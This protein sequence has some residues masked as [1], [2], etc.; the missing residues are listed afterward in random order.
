MQ[1]P[2][3]R[4]GEDANLKKKISAYLSSTEVGKLNQGP[5]SLYTNA[6]IFE[7]YRMTDLTLVIGQHMSKLQYNTA[8]SVMEGHRNTVAAYRICGILVRMGIS[9][10]QTLMRS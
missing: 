2:T 8:Q 9:Q 5:E 1:S 10:G 4:E 7:R 3:G 6:T